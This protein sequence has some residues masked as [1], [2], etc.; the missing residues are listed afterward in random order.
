MWGVAPRACRHDV[1]HRATKALKIDAYR[2]TVVEATRGEVPG[3]D[4]YRG[5]KRQRADEDTRL[6]QI[7]NHRKAMTFIT[8]S[9]AF[10]D[11]FNQVCLRVF[12]HT[13]V[14]SVSSPKIDPKLTEVGQEFTQENLTVN[15]WSG[16][17][18]RG[19]QSGASPPPNTAGF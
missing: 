6:G 17:S 16:L 7:R 13:S 9:W 4:K 5:R 10:C 18:W 11:E 14:I 12:V 2:Q 19:S 15:L 3:L 1:G 8:S